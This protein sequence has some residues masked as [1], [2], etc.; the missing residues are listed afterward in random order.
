MIKKLKIL[1]L[2]PA[3]RVGST[4]FLSLTDRH[5]QIMQ[6]PGEF[7]FD[8]FWSKIK[9]KSNSE[10]I[11]NIFLRD[12][13]YFF[14]SQYNKVDR[15]NQLGSKRNKIFKV[16]TILFYKNF[17]KFF[18][19]KNNLNKKIHIINSLHLAYSSASG[20]IVKKKKL[21]VINA[22]D[23]S[24]LK[25]YE[26]VDVSIVYMIRHPIAIL[27]S[28]FKNWMSYKNGILLRPRSFL[29][30]CNKLILGLP[31]ILKM[32]KKTY[33]IQLEILHKNSHFLLKDFCKIFH[34]KLKKSLFIS[35]FHGLRWWGDS[36]SGKF[37]HGFNINFKNEIY[38]KNFYKKDIYTIEKSLNYFLKKYNY[39]K[40]NRSVIFSFPYLN[41]LPFKMELKLLKKSFY[42]F[43][44]VDIFLF[45]L[46]LIL[47]IK[48]TSGTINYKKLP[49]SIGTRK[50]KKKSIANYY[51]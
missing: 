1:L 51:S 46:Y 29:F 19:Q 26:E 35:T 21:I 40:K 39:S 7:F 23:Y 24:R 36:V 20:E 25:V 10:E 28:S 8:E 43:D 49:Y 13:K 42:N 37:L 48:I 33:I 30:F 12:Y 14:N 15:L 34:I 41:F 32:K 5:E 18:K 16:S 27:N 17:C 38:E 44:F 2:I 31:S 45:P 50:I 4:F 11:C 9:N 3:G 47:R 6:F 22:H